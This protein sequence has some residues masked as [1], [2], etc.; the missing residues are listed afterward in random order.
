MFIELKSIKF[1]CIKNSIFNAFQH[2]EKDDN[3]KVV[4]ENVLR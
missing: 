3:L 2:Y 4:A 1:I